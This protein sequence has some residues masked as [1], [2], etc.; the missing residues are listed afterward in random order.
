M[1]AQVLALILL[2]QY[3]SHILSVATFYSVSQNVINLNRTALRKLK[4]ISD[5]NLKLLAG[6]YN[7]K[8]D[9]PH[10]TSDLCLEMSTRIRTQF[11]AK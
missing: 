5:S 6:P 2:A 4:R 10:P 3:F 9:P 11:L 7:R 8:I 1:L